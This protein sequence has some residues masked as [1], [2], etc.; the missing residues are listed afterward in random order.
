M[1]LTKWDPFE[2]LADLESSLGRALLG[3]RETPAT[4]SQNK[5]VGIK[6]DW[7]PAVDIHEDNEAYYFD[8][9]APGIEKDKFDISLQNSVLTLKGERSFEN[10]KEGK[11]YYRVERE[12]GSFAR[13]FTLPE[14][15]DPAKVLAEYKNGILHV[16]VGKKE[17]AKPQKINVQVA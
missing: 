8:V 1:F 5:E 6:S 2:G 15:A 11:N 3:R 7:Y 10:K 13:S 4:Q 14:T 16:K 9:E 17:V 12:Y